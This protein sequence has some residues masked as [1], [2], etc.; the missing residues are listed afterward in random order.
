MTK[1]VLDIHDIRETSKRF[2]G[3]KDVA[4]GVDDVARLQS[5][6]AEMVKLLKTASKDYDNLKDVMAA[7]RGNTIALFLDNVHNDFPGTLTSFMTSMKSLK[8][9]SAALRV[10]VQ[11]VSVVDQQQAVDPEVTIMEDI[12]G[13]FDGAIFG[14]E[15]KLEAFDTTNDESAI[16]DE[17]DKLDLFRQV[18][19]IIVANEGMFNDFFSKLNDINILMATPAELN[20]LEASLHEVNDTLELC[21]D[22]FPHRDTLFAWTRLGVRVED[23][24]KRLVQRVENFANK[25]SEPIKDME[26]TTVLGA[27]LK[28]ALGL[29][30]H[31]CSLCLDKKFS[32]TTCS[33]C[34]EANV[35][36]DCYSTHILKAREGGLPTMQKSLMFACVMAPS[37]GCHGAYPEELV[38]KMLNLDATHALRDLNTEVEYAKKHQEDMLAKKMETR[39]QTESMTPMDRM[40]HDE[41][42]R[43]S[44]KISNSCRT[45]LTPFA[46]FVGCAAVTC[47]S[48][49]QNFCALCLDPCP[50]GMN[51]HEHV[52][53]CRLRHRFRSIEDGVFVTLPN[54]KKGRASILNEELIKYVRELPFDG[55][56][57]DG[58]MFKG[59]LVETFTNDDARMP[60]PRGTEH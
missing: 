12:F 59:K 25:I 49:S 38:H 10:E 2:R 8:A 18:Q 39:R 36:G 43:L 30:A 42:E 13:D 29:K 22:F 54:W 57:S 21:D 19:T 5:T 27:T 3:I 55:Q 1:R 14:E 50:P 60:L 28:T 51:D 53:S 24:V 34:L 7:I 46:D 48:C 41:F 15:D 58:K 26:D 32:T 37:S 45:C 47:G 6:F 17:E 11:H 35:C 9:K 40:Y 44:Q 33:D 20:Q 56:L 23:R 16:E 31:M 4:T 52:R